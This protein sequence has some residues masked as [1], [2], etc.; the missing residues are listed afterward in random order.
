MKRRKFLQVLSGFLAAMAV[1]FAFGK[2]ESQIFTG[3]ILRLGIDDGSSTTIDKDCVITWQGAVIPVVC[4]QDFSKQIGE[5]QLERTDGAGVVPEE[6]IAK[7]KV[8]ENIDLQVFKNG[9]C[10]VSGMIKKGD[11][12]H[13]I[14]GYTCQVKDFHLTH[15]SW[16]E[17]NVDKGIKAV[18][19]WSQG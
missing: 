13:P 4:S 1:P 12:K 10:S 7:V 8:Y 5:A 16:P 11:Y 19:Y 15:I 17:K 14:G 6:L 9:Y 3:T 18:K 2:K